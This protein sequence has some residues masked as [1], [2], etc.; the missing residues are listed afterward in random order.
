LQ[1]RSPSAPPEDSRQ[2]L[3]L[4]GRPPAFA[5]GAIDRQAAPW[6]LGFTGPCVAGAQEARMIPQH[7]Q[8]PGSDER[9]IA[10]T[11]R[12]LARHGYVSLT[13]E[14][15]V[16]AAG[17]SRQDF[18]RRFAGKEGAVGA[19]HEAIFERLLG[20]IA[21]ACEDRREW[22]LKVTAAIGSA[23]DFAAA[24][25]EQAQLLTVESVAT[26]PRLARQVLGSLDRLAAMLGEGRRQRPAAA[27]LPALTEKAQV[28]AIA[29]IV[30][31]CLMNGESERLPGLKA[32]F[33]ELTLLPYIGAAEAA[34]AAGGSA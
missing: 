28:G 15:V 14:H 24:D 18:D 27:R 21:R 17:V 33:A 19:A 6:S 9:L 34:R 25:P 22:P 1:R 31:G 13:V 23:L 11:A 8:S 5:G 30:A 10:A 7:S 32:Q 20:S 26:E 16:A 2:G 3:I 12:A 29:S 4:R